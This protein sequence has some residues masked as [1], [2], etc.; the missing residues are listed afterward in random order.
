VLELLEWEKETKFQSL[1]AKGAVLVSQWEKETKFQSLGAKGA[2]LVSQRSFYRGRKRDLDLAAQLSTNTRLGGYFKRKGSLGPCILAPAYHFSPLIDARAG[3]QI[4]FR[5]DIVLERLKWL[6]EVVDPK[7]Q[8]QKK[9]AAALPRSTVQLYAVVSAFFSRLVRHHSKHVER[10]PGTTELAENI[11]VQASRD[12]VDGTFAHIK[13]S[14]VNGALVLR[15]WAAK[16]YSSSTLPRGRMSYRNRREALINSEDFQE[17][18]RAVLR[19]RPGVITTASAT[20]QFQALLRVLLPG[21]LKL[22]SL[23]DSTVRRWLR[24]LGYRHKIIDKG[25]IYFDGHNR[26]DVVLYRQT[27]YVPKMGKL[28][29]RLQDYQRTEDRKSWVPVGGQFDGKEVVLL[30]Q[31]EST[32]MTSDTVRVGW[33]DSSGHGTGLKTKKRGQGIMISGYINART[34][35]LR[36]SNEEFEEAKKAGY[37]GPQDSTETLEFGKGNWWTGESQ[38]LQV[39]N[40]VLPLVNLL[41]PPEKFEVVVVY[42]HSTCHSCYADDALKAERLNL[43]DGGKKKPRPPAIS[44]SDWD[45]KPHVETVWA[46]RPTT[47]SRTDQDGNTVQVEQAMHLNDGLPKGMKTVL[48]ERGI[49]MTDSS[50]K[51]LLATCVLCSTQGGLYDGKDRDC[52]CYRHVLSL[53]PDFKAERPLVER[54]LTAAGVGCLFLPKFH[55]ELNPIELVWA[56][57]KA[58]IRKRNDCTLA[59]LRVALDEE[60]ANIGLALVRGC[61]MRVRRYVDAY[62]RGLTGGLA[63]YAVTIFKSHR[64]IPGHIVD[65]LEEM[66]VAGEISEHPTADEQTKVRKLK[67]AHSPP[68]PPQPAHSKANAFS[69]G[70]GTMPAPADVLAQLAKNRGEDL[71]PPPPAAAAAAPPPPSAALSKADAA[72]GVISALKSENVW[73]SPAVTVT[74]QALLR[75]FRTGKAAYL[76]DELLIAFADIMHR[77]A[78]RQVRPGPPVYVVSSLTF[79]LFANPL[80]PEDE[81]IVKRQCIAL[82]ATHGISFKNCTLVFIVNTKMHWL[83]VHCKFKDNVVAELIVEESLPATGAATN[84]IPNILKFALY[85]PAVTLPFDLAGRSTMPTILTNVTPQTDSYS[86]GTF[87]AVKLAML[88]LHGS[89]YHDAITQQQIDQYKAQFALVVLQDKFATQAGQGLLIELRSVLDLTLTVNDFCF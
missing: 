72:L 77:K 17:M 80:V 69:L 46:L 83:L 30:F 54:T 48:S 86:C 68:R 35:V 2:V 85:L 26:D 67:A 71:A 19:S 75:L 42:D 34:G 49:S 89:V 38:V 15:Q 64:R 18:A 63:K 78:S 41:F 51:A 44:K 61:C 70:E 82:K 20:K 73:A 52:C 59:T 43:S 62:S 40:S 45:K 76:N 87:V 50:G 47:F 79:A 25:G 66:V 55:C 81:V 36:M 24:E 27:E 14:T 23:S 8:Q 31:D 39:K 88:L 65:K 11:R 29:E 74:I 22:P 6:A 28:F 10:N 53:Q 12:V 3:P 32:V 57:L 37:S 56:A 13:R 21:V 9:A 84:A 5:L 33:A 58:Q 60:W 7:N 4:E 1:G 16:F